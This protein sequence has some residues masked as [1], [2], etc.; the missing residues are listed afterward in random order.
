VPDRGPDC[1]F[2]TFAGRRSDLGHRC[3]RDPDGR[4][5]TLTSG[6]F[7]LLLMLA[8]RPQ[9]LL[10]RDQLL[11]L[12]KGRHA[13]PFDRSIDVQLCWCRRSATTW[14]TRAAASSSRGR[15]A[16]ASP[17]APWAL[18]RAL[19]N[20]IDNAVIYGER[21]EVTADSDGSSI[22]LTVADRGPGVPEAMREQVFQPL[23]R[24]EPSHPRD[25][26]GTGLA[27]RWRA[28]SSSGTAARSPWTTDLPAA[29]R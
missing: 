19:V 8:E 9:R 24:M 5:V 13:Q 3:L 1:G 16:S 4:L 14:R 7:D 23:F 6:E 2:L 20:L 12:T 26:G 29:S 27:S 21:A 15:P 22:H 11:D 10:S 17:V 18:R 28:P 25:T